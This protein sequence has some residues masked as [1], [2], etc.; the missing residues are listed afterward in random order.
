MSFIT[1][2]P[3]I[4]PNRYILQLFN[5]FQTVFIGTHSTL[6]KTKTQPT[7]NPCYTNAFG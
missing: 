1:D 6:F 3:K 4:K 2:H 5:L 7:V